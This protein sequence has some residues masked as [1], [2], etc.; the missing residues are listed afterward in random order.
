MSRK[1]ERFDNVTITSV[2]DG[3]TIQGHEAVQAHFEKEQKLLDEHGS[4]IT[5]QLYRPN[6][7]ATTA[8][9][10][11]GERVAEVKVDAAFVTGTDSVIAVKQKLSH[12]LGPSRP[13]LN[14]ADPARVTFYFG[15]RPMRDQALFFADHFMLVPAWV[16]VV[17]HDCGFEELNAVVER[18]R[19]AGRK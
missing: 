8:A 12:V 17:L 2:V 14:L 11:Q 19:V 4:T 5:F 6:L 10:L 9:E 13:D 16:Q 3:T 15:G 7:A 18:L 1:P